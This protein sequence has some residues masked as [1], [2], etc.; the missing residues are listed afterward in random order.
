[1]NR[2]TVTLLGL[3]FL[4]LI[5]EG[6][7]SPARG[8]IY[9]YQDEDGYWHFPQL[10]PSN[11]ESM[12]AQRAKGWQKDFF[13]ACYRPYIMAVCRK[14]KVNAALVM[15]IIMA[16]SDCDRTAVSRK[17]AMGL[18]QL[19][20]R[21]AER[22]NVGNPFSPRNNIEGGVRYLRYLL[23]RFHNDIALT[24]AAYNCGASR[25][26][27]AGGIPPIPET[28]QFVHKVLSFYHQFKSAA[29]N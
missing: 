21:T 24:A 25:V 15:A 9:G 17:G 3:L 12:P 5:T 6:I 23:G 16:E 27:A 4:V 2:I 26:E 11:T 13:I 22:L 1:M 28:R 19:M 7:L 8:Q 29:R 14:Y 18:M 20:P 10:N